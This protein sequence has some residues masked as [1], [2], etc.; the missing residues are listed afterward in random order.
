[1]IDTVSALAHWLYLCCKTC[2]AM[3]GVWENLISLHELL[4]H[5]EVPM[6]SSNEIS[7]PVLL[8]GGPSSKA[9]SGIA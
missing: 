1:M 2:V 4:V 9:V 7:F 5:L 8:G 6:S 3:G